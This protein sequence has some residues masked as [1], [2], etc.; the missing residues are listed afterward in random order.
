MQKMI[1]AMQRL[2]APGPAHARLGPL[3][4]DWDTVTT[5]YMGP[6]EVQTQG[7]ARKVWVLGGRFLQ[8]ELAGTG[9]DGRAY[10]GIGLLGH[11]NARG[12]YQ[13]MWVSDGMTSMTTYSGGADEGG[14]RF[15]FSGEESDPSGQGPARAFV[16]EL[17]VEDPDA[18]TLTQFYVSSEGERMRAFEIRHTRRR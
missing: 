18:H 16:T 17:A 4:G 10:Q 9:P 3:A 13:G 6:R 7:T 11:D 14:R 5:I 12:V 2:A 8:E 1:A 15:T